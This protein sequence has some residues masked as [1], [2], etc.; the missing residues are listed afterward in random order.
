MCGVGWGGVKMGWGFISLGLSLG[1]S[2][3]TP[4][5]ALRASAALRMHISGLSWKLRN[6]A[7]GALH[8]EGQRLEQTNTHILNRRVLVFEDRFK[9]V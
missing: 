5:T 6:A 4:C 9:L 7:S 2:C 3:R 8:V 1:Q